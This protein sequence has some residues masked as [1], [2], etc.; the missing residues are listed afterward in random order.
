MRWIQDSS[1]A[2]KKLK[3][4]RIFS[5]E[6]L[7]TLGFSGKFVLLEVR[8]LLHSVPKQTHKFSSSV[9]VILET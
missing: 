6:A 9:D 5:R 7:P 1:G 4:L 8:K 3:K 2:W